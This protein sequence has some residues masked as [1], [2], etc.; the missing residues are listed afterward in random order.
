M[1]VVGLILDGVFLTIV[2]TPPAADPLTVSQEN[3]FTVEVDEHGRFTIVG[4]DQ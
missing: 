1:S 4:I 3:Q 2:D